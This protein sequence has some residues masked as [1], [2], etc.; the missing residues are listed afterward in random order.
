MVNAEA[1]RTEWS[2]AKKII[3]QQMYPRN[4]I[5]RLWKLKD[6]LPNIMVL[7]NLALIKK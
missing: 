7:A 2:M 5:K 6:S 3:M 4:N 1:S